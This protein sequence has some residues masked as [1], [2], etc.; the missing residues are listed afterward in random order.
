MK[1]LVLNCGSSSLKFQIIEKIPEDAYRKL[2]RGNIRCIGGEATFDFQ[3]SGGSPNSGKISARDHEDAVRFVFNWLS[4][5][6]HSFSGSEMSYDIDAVG[7]R[8]VHGGTR[9]TAPV[10]IDNGVIGEI[11]SLNDLAPLHNPVCVKGIR[12]TRSILGDSVPMVAVF[13]TAFHHTIPEYASTYALPHEISI[14]HRIRRYG[15]H[16]TAHR[17]L[18]ERYSE[19][20]SSPIGHS[21]VITLQLGNGCSVTATKNGKSV[22]T[23]M[24][25]TPL[26]GLVMGT[27]SGDLDPA[28]IFYLA[29]KE[30]LDVTTIDT[31]LN[32]QSG[33]L[34]ISGY[35]NDMSELLERAQI[36][37]EHRVRL[38]VD[39]FCYRVRKYIGSYL[40]ALEGADAIVF[41]GGIGENSPLVREM[42]CRG[43]EWSGLKL[44]TG[45]NAATVG[46]DGRISS[47]DATIHAY[48]I[49]VD[50]EL[51]IARDTVDVLSREGDISKILK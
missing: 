18:A 20:T 30:R 37:D 5:G 49:S 36:S 13:D 8:V 38:A 2:S 10:L 27:R 9:F 42:I 41:S 51:L 35:S 32:K 34:G 25:F 44:D 29:R 47:D 19:I 28:I 15:F 46:A 26:E 16:G 48:V 43:M 31:L 23:S 11:E 40:A 33:L 4:S 6:E 21:K 50:E 3:I 14:K 7:H 39:I 1:I 24:G 17:F 12:A 45:R 22:D